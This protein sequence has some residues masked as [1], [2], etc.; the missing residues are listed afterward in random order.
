MVIRLVNWL[1]YPVNNI[2]ELIDDCK[3]EKENFHSASRFELCIKH[4]DNL[5]TRED[6]WT[7]SISTLSWIRC[8][9]GITMLI[10]G[11]P[12][13]LTCSADLWMTAQQFSNTSPEQWSRC[14]W[15]DMMIGR[16]LEMKSLVH[17]PSRQYKITSLSVW[18]NWEEE[19][20][21]EAGE[22]EDE[23]RW[24]GNGRKMRMI[25]DQVGRSWK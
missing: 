8:L 22:E 6:Q 9:P 17:Q 1:I 19:K 7:G 10:G 24:T 2:H 21:E 3:G 5:S 4:H 11:D 12:G 13:R 20:E 25:V 18:W 14:P 16:G 15:G 23:W